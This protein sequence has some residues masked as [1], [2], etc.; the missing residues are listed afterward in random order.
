[1]SSVRVLVV[2]DFE[3]FRRYIVSALQSMPQ[4]EVICGVSDGLE[5][6]QK[7]RELQPDLIVLDIGLPR[8]NGIEVARQVSK[9][10]P[11]SKVLFVSQECSAE[12]V[13]QAFDVGALGYV[14][15]TD[16]GRDLVTAASSVL[17]NERFV[18][19]RAAGYDFRGVSLSEGSNGPSTSS[20]VSR[21]EV[22][23]QRKA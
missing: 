14:V 1:M 20:H 19:S 16:A 13:Q 18:S 12:I 17:R 7:A 22:R 15:K 10:A 11:R 3:P 6:V 5:A 23:A 8:M 21:H 2:D 9:L 4:V